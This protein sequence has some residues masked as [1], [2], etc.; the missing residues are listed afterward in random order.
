MGD[1]HLFVTSVLIEGDADIERFAAVARERFRSVWPLGGIALAMYDKDFDGVSS[2]IDMIDTC[3]ALAGILE[4]DI[5]I[6]AAWEPYGASE[7]RRVWRVAGRSDQLRLP[8]IA[9]QHDPLSVA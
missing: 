7:K 8:V 4:H 3:E 9:G 6:V 2:A 5:H 1:Q